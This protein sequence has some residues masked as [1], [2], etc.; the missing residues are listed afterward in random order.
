[1]SKNDQQ[2]DL[3]VPY[4]DY[5]GEFRT[6]KPNAQTQLWR[7]L[8]TFK[9]TMC[10][11]WLQWCPTLCDPDCSPPELSSGITRQEYWVGGHAFS[12]SVFPTR[13]WN[14]ISYVSCTGMPGCLP[15][16][17]PGEDENTT[18]PQASHCFI[19]DVGRLDSWEESYISA[20]LDI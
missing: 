7:S 10:A 17:S 13:G 5:D 9:N 11:K 19:W 4:F 14:S 18:I 3:A 20:S 12:G 16:A 15:P 2:I 1:M 6:K 8:K